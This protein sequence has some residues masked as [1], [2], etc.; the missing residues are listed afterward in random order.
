MFGKISAES[1]PKSISQM[2]TIN[3]FFYFPGSTHEIREKLI[4]LHPSKKQVPENILL[5]L[6][7]YNCRQVLALNAV[8]K[9]VDAELLPLIGNVSRTEGAGDGLMGPGHHCVK[10]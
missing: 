7:P 2:G 4:H 3:Y 9:K 6:H 10:G 5:I 8:A 1:S